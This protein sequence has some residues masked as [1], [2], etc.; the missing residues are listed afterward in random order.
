MTRD[1]GDAIRIH[2]HIRRLRYGHEHHANLV[3]SPLLLRTIWFYDVISCELVVI[4]LALVK[5]RKLYHII[6]CG[7]G[8]YTWSVRSPEHVLV[9]I[10]IYSTT[11]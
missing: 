8:L 10:R 9:L 7:G 6:R 4:I 3:G 1:W 11:H 5:V 2:S